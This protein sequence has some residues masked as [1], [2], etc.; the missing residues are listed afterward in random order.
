MGFRPTGLRRCRAMTVTAA[1]T[2]S[3]YARVPSTMLREL[4]L[5]AGLDGRTR[6]EA[7]RLALEA[8]VSAVATTRDAAQEANASA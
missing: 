8:Y 5:A 7:I 3:V 4:D 1:K 6:S 2:S